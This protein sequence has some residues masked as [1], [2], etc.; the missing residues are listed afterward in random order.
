MFNEEQQV[1]DNLAEKGVVE[2]RGFHLDKNINI[3]AVFA[4]IVLMITLIGYGN[5]IL[6]EMKEMDTKTKIMWSMFIKEHP[7][8][9]IIYGDSK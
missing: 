1:V 9:V 4:G 7:E 5:A 2:R 8:Y 3:S 6:N